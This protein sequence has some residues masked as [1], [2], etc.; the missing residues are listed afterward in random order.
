[1]RKKRLW[2]R[3]HIARQ[4]ACHRQASGPG[5]D[6]LPHQRH[7]AISH[8][9]TPHGRISRCRRI[10]IESRASRPPVGVGLWARIWGAKLMICLICWRVGFANASDGAFPGTP[11]ALNR[12]S[13]AIQNHS[14]RPRWCRD[15]RGLTIQART[16][17]LI[18][19][20]NMITQ[21]ILH[22]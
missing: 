10:K 15:K 14:R 6:L 5:D 20:G 22:E 12:D 8:V 9:V 7:T 18:N 17:V 11:C 16:I 21:P 13:P 2:E 1:M 19:V 4:M 3:G